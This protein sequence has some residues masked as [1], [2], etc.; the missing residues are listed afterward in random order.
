MVGSVGIWGCMSNEGTGCCATYAGRLNADRYIEILDNE[1]V[2]SIEL[3][4]SPGSSEFLFQQ[5]NAPCHRAKKVKEHLSQSIELL[6]WP[7]RSPDH[8][9]VIIDRKLAD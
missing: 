8:L 2:P 9:W 6:P 1:L 3:L 4:T 5:D 7:A